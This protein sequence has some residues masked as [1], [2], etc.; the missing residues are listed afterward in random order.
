MKTNTEKIREHLEATG[1]ISPAEARIVHGIERLAPRIMELRAE[2]M[3]I[4]TTVALDEAEHR[5]TRYIHH[6]GV[7]RS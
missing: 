5:Y 7:A 4:D 2:G 6:P 3:G 1:H